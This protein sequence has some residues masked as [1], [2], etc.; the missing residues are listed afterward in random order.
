MSV[1]RRPAFGA[2][3]LA[4]VLA[5]AAAPARAGEAS[6]RIVLR[7]S[8]AAAG[9][10]VRVTGTG[11][12]VRLRVT[13]YFTVPRSDAHVVLAT[14]RASALGG[15][16]TSFRVRGTDKR[17]RYGIVACQLACRA[18]AQAALRVT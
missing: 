17:G 3:V 7:P 15:F 1:P 9:Q 11:F 14:P 5:A 2:L 13:V 18:K 4:L 10:T 6:A 8:R 16:R 12:R